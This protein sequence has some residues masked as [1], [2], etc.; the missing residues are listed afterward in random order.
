[1]VCYLIHPYLSLFPRPQTPRIGIWEWSLQLLYTWHFRY[2]HTSPGCYLFFCHCRHHFIPFPSGD[3]GGDTVHNSAFSL[4]IGLG[5]L[6][7]DYSIH[8]LHHICVGLSHGLPLPFDLAVADWSRGSISELVRSDH[9]HFQI[10]INR[11]LRSD[12]C[13]NIIYIPQNA[14]SLSSARI[15]VWTN[16]LFGF[17]ATRNFGTMIDLFML[18]LI[19]LHNFFIH[20][21]DHHFPILDVRC[22]RP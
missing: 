15:C 13:K 17:H 5:Q 16:I 8:L 4:S 22:L 21:S 18:P 2:Q 11:N 10:S 12:V 6:D 3:S 19:Y 9:L 14:Y 7:R 20:D 1:M